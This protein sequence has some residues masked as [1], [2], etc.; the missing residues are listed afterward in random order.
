MSDSA[1][2][3][4]DSKHDQ[5][6]ARLLPE[7]LDHVPEPILIADNERKYVDVNQ[8]AVKALGGT[9]E[10]IIGRSIDDYFSQ[11]D[12]QPIPDF[13]RKF[14]A[15]G[16]LYGTCKL[17]QPPGSIFVYRCRAN[18]RSGLHVGVLRRIK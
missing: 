14:I 15:A 6:P 9:R 16:D 13:W 10:T 12:D 11:A 3:L 5:K 2:F 17:R 7:Q 8:A 18:V 4:D 1:G